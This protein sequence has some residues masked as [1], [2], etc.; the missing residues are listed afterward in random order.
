MEDRDQVV[1]SQPPSNITVHA[2]ESVKGTELDDTQRQPEADMDFS[3]PPEV[4]GHYISGP[5]W[6]RAD[7]EPTPLK[8][9]WESDLDEYCHLRR[10][11][12]LSFDD[13]MEDEGEQSAESPPPS[14]ATGEPP[15][16]VDDTSPND[17]SDSQTPYIYTEADQGAD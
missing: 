13:R 5:P 14:D 11:V 16:P 12:S 9:V 15:D 3:D 4:R 1:E 10:A 8:L 6:P 7:S 2:P 17:I